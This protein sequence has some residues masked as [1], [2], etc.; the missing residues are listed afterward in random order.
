[1]K[2][3]VKK[4]QD[5]AAKLKEQERMINLA[6]TEKRELTAEENA[7]LDALD[8]E[9]ETLEGEIEAAE[10]A[11]KREERIIALSG[12]IVPEDGNDPEQREIN[13]MRQRFSFSKALRAVSEN[14]NL[15]GLEKEMNEEA[16][17]E[18]KTIGLDF[19]STN[20]SFSIPAKMVR[21]TSQSVTGD[22]GDFGSAF[23]PTDIRPVEGFIPRLFLEDVGATFLTGLSGNISLPKAGD[24]EY[25]WLNENENIVLEATK[26][27]GPTLKPHRAGAGVEISN[28]L[29]M[30]SSVDVENMI[31]NKLRFAAAKVLNQAAL[32]G[33]GG[34]APVG[35]LNT[36]GI[37]LAAATA[38]EEV[39]YEAIVELWGL[40]ANAN[41]DAG[42]E[43]YILNSKLAAALRTA[44]KD[45]GSGRF[46]ME[47]GLIDGQKTIVTNLVEELA[48]LQTLIY[49]NFSELFIGQWGGVNFIADPYT[50]AGSSKLVVYSNLFADTQIVNPEAFAVNK[51]LKA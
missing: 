8:A 21:A 10:R 27:D 3:S 43:A 16:L 17:R 20:R 4:K 50:K 19:D 46:V 38:E 49:G 9:I 32:N 1:M 48:D 45:G 42:N 29:L 25:N 7:Q 2:K 22:S 13:E 34:K 51:F 14:R 39:S 36:P 11:E 44:K 28:Q 47:N 37:L 26:I 24:F 35:I 41:A 31:Y 30:Q 12:N 40:I 33:A 15:E 23:V 18:A 5:R 6:K